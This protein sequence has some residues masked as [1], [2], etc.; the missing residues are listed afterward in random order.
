MFLIFGDEI[1]D[2]SVG[3]FLNKVH[4]DIESELKG[5]L[6]FLLFWESGIVEKE[7]NIAVNHMVENGFIDG[8]LRLLLLLG[9]VLNV[10]NCRAGEKTGVY[11]FCT[12]WTY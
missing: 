5:G 1:L 6:W 3:F 7:F 4:G 8:G 2:I 10:E 9:K 11:H 12:W